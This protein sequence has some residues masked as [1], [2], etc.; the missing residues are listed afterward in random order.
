MKKKIRIKQILACLLVFLWMI[1]IFVFSSQIESESSKLS[2]GITD[3][4]LELLNPIRLSLAWSKEGF[5]HFIRKMGHFGEYMILSLLFTYALRVNLSMSWKSLRLL[6]VSFCFFYAV[7]DEFH[8]YFVSGRVASF[9]DVCIDS[10][11]ALFA[12]I[13]YFLFRRKR[14]FKNKRYEL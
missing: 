7:T 12:F 8:Q 14:N 1:L 6:T 2:T 4:I 13:L 9:V 10:S 5:H 3:F 11:G